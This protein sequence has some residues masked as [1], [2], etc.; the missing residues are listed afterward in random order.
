[1]SEALRTYSGRIS[2]PKTKR[3]T[4]G[5]RLFRLRYLILVALIVV[6]AVAAWV[7]RDK[8][9]IAGLMPAGRKYSLICTDLLNTRKRIAQSA[10]W[11][12]LPED[13]RLATLPR[14][15]GQELRL[16]ETLPGSVPDWVINNLF[17]ENLYITGNDLDTFSDALVLT[18]MSRIGR[19][20]EYL[21]VFLGGIERDWAGG[22][23]LRRLPGQGIYYAVRGRVL[24]LSKSRTA[25]VRSLTL[26]PDQ[27]VTPDS[28]AATASEVG[29]EDARGAL[30]LSPDDP[31]GAVFE[32]VRFALRID[33]EE[34]Q[35]KCRGRF[36]P[37][38]RRQWGVLLDGVTPASLTAAPEG[39]LSVSADFGKPVDEIWA[40]LG[41]IIAGALDPATADASSAEEQW[42][43]WS[44]VEPGAEVGFRPFMTNLT[45]PLGPGFRLAWRGVDLNELVPVPR[46]VGSFDAP[47]GA[48][49]RFIEQ[50]PSA[51]PDAPSWAS[52]PRRDEE[53]GRIWLPLFGGPSLQ[54]TALARDTQILVSTSADLAEPFLEEGTAGESL[55]DKG[56]LFVTAQ[57]FLCVESIVEAGTLLAQQ[58]ALRGHS[59]ESYR[60]TTARW[61]ASAAAIETDHRLGGRRTRRNHFGHSPGLPRARPRRFRARR[62]GVKHDR[63][64]ID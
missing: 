12:T 39:I 38:W 53:S 49:D 8:Q 64:R 1:M 20:V 54:P 7:T 4:H 18:K 58:G 47:I 62:R 41:A 15:L 45:G 50:L 33:A 52:Y 32:H 23:H 36:R 21:H 28:L 6:G 10:V 14:V 22:L 34:G 57:P 44:Q 60:V 16:P 9:P 30:A 56:N 27:A 19:L 61:L 29:R 46:V 51:P 40:G 31:L 48:L 26:P 43:R 25:I 35:L 24:V 63:P 17:Y 59:E 42:R 55:P 37:E 5:P 11:Q 2:K 13:S 3:R